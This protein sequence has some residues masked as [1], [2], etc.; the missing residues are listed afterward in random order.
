[1]LTSIGLSPRVPGL[2]ALIVSVTLGL[3]YTAGAQSLPAGWSMSDIGGPPT[4]GSATVSAGTFSLSSRGWDVNGASD[5]FTFVY[6]TAK[7]DFSLVAKL[8]S[9]QNTDAWSQVGLMIRE[10]LN[11]SSVHA[12]ILATSGNGLVVRTRVSDHGG[13]TQTMSG[14]SAGPVWLR[15]DRRSSTLVAYRS[16]DGVNWTSVSSTKLKLNQSALV[17]FAVASHSTSTSVAAALSAATLN[18]AAAP[19]SALRPPSVNVPPTVS[20]TAPGNGATF[21]TPASISLAATA[22]DSDGSVSKVA[23]YNGTTLLGSDT[24]SPYTFAWTNV[25]T[26]SYTLKAVAT[27]NAGGSTTSGVVNVIVNANTA[28]AVTLTSPSSGTSF[29]APATTT[30]SATATDANGSIARVDFFAGSTLLGSDTSSP[31]AANWSNVPA[32]TYVLTAKA[33][34]NA[35]VSTT[36]AGVSVTVK[37]NQAPTVSLTSPSSGAAFT[38]PASIGLTASASDVDGSVQKVEFYNGT[39]LL[40]SAT[41]SPFAFTWSNVPAGSYSV[42]AVARDNMGA[43]TVSS[44]RDVT[45][46]ATQLSTATFAPAI[47]PDSVA[48]YIFEVFAAGSDPNM[49]APLT[50]Q[51]LGIPSVVNGECSVDVRNTLAGLAPGSYVATVSAVTAAE[52]V[53]RSAAFAFSR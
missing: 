4:A 21:G 17:G 41:A 20:L 25:Q 16:A 34:D 40:G 11:A 38:A 1:V 43:T 48:Y 50:S 7:H 2:V 42:S 6:T 27:D 44:W 32:G 24:T 39:T 15:I 3:P 31:Y 37:A 36:S 52:G 45:V 28:P 26:G 19:V 10:S 18:G 33:T 22:A 51:N 5:Q 46:A 30:I 8:T 23:F 47:V 53:L 35:G 49:A 12:S 14:P 9:L 13:T 29:M